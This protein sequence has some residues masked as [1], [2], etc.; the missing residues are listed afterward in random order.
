MADISKCQNEGC[1][2]KEKCHRYTTKDSKW[3]SYAKFKV[4]RG[5][6]KCDCFWNN[7]EYIGRRNATP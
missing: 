6:K 1:P 4:P 5:H 3:Q 2:S 7:N